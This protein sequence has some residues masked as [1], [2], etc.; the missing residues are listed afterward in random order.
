MQTNFMD[1]DEDLMQPN[2]RAIGR[3]ESF[4]EMQ[5]TTSN[6]GQKSPSK[7]TFMDKLLEEMN[8]PEDRP[9]VGRKIDFLQAEK[10]KETINL[11]G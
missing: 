11:F 1:E 2:L 10:G 8:C 7:I 5:N 4:A 6:V 9:K 3:S